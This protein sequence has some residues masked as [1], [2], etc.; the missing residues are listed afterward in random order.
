MRF[1]F[2]SE[3]HA[4]GT[5]GDAFSLSHPSCLIVSSANASRAVQPTSPLSVEELTDDPESHLQDLSTTCVMPRRTNGKQQRE[6]ED[7]SHP[8]PADDDEDV[9]S[10]GI[11][12]KFQLKRALHTEHHEDDAHSDDVRQKSRQ[13]FRLGRHRNR[14]AGAVPAENAAK[15]LSPP[16][17]DRRRPSPS[18]KS[19]NFVGLRKPLLQRTMSMPHDLK[20]ASSEETLALETASNSVPP[21]GQRGHRRH[22]TFSN[23]QVREYSRILGDHPCCPS[24]LPLSLGWELEREDSFRL[25][26]YEKK[27]EPTRRSKEDFRLGYQDRREILESLVISPQSSDSECEGALQM[28]VTCP[29]Y[30]RA[31]MR[32]AERRLSRERAENHRAVRKVNNRFFKVMERESISCD[33]VSLAPDEEPHEVSV[34]ASIRICKDLSAASWF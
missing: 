1:H 20:S 32:K 29:M 23:V 15:S 33:I 4:T 34:D 27:R 21:T 11:S 18:G 30:S 19:R 24:G 31:E 10:I 17:T 16:P 3:T 5:I 9:P 28:N 26:E 2:R 25:E 7:R 6:T 8:N 22:V 12:A 13:F 14:S